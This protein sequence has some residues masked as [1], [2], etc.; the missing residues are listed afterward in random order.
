L[1]LTSSQLIEIHNKIQNTFKT[2][3]GIKNP[4]LIQAVVERPDQVLYGK[5]SFP[6]IYL[7]A[8]ALMEALMRWHVFID[9]NKRTGLLATETYLK[10]N[11]YVC[12]F[13]IKVVRFSVDIARTMGTDQDTTKLLIDKV[14]TWLRKYIVKDDDIRNAIP[15]IKNFIEENK[16]FADLYKKDTQKANELVNEW[17]AIDVYPEYSRTAGQVM[18][19]ITDMNSDALNYIDEKSK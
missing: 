7:K 14:A 3:T 5:E 15:I 12:F 6:D 11:G 4:G 9:G 17:L 1:N 2:T 10:L 16:R 13:P 18:L 19:F 8:A